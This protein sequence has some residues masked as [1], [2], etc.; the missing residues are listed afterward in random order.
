MKLLKMRSDRLGFRASFQ[1]GEGSEIEYNVD[2]YLDSSHWGREHT[3]TEK[4]D[5]MRVGTTIN[6]KCEHETATQAS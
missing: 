5:P 6:I 2:H 3:I 1:I 4:I